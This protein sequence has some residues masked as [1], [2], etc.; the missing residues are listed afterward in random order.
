[1]D[2]NLVFEIIN[3]I[4]KKPDVQFGLSEFEKINP[5]EI[6]KIFEKEKGIVGPAEGAKPREI[7]ID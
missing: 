4:F 3:K 2:K 1:M 6:L 5:S 7:L